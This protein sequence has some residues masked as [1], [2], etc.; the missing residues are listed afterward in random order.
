[1]PT[2]RDIDA[3]GHFN[4]KVE[5]EGVTQ[6]PFIA[7]EM[8]ESA[9]AVIESKRGNDLWVRKTPGRHGYGNIVL[10]RAY[11]G[12]DTLWTWRKAVTDGKVERKAG[13]IIIADGTAEGEITRFNFFEGWPCRW[14]LG[15]WDAD[16]DGFL[17]EEI[18][19]TVEKIEKG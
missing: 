5:I 18:E 10:R 2:R 6:G 8:L 3:I 16:S 15:T 12:D 9:T 13:S 14:C 11:T 7:V 4:F 19:I 17:V 1:M